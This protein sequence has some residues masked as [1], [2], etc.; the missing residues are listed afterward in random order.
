MSGGPARSGSPPSA[1][2]NDPRRAQAAAAAECVLAQDPITM[3]FLR[4]RGKQLA[5]WRELEFVEETAPALSPE[6]LRSAEA[7]DR[8]PMVNIRSDLP[9]EE[10][11][12][13]DKDYIRLYCLA[14]KYAMHTPADAFARSAREQEFVTFAHLV[15]EP[16]KFRG[17]VVHL[18]G[19][20]R[21]LRRFDAPS[22]AQAEG[23]RYAYEGWIM[24]PTRG[25]TPFCVVVPVLPEGLEPAESMD[26]YVKFDGYFL[27]RFKYLSGES[28]EKESF[29]F[30]GPSVAPTKAPPR[31]P[32]SPLIA[33]WLLYAFVGFLITMVVMILVLSWWFRRGDLKIRA[34]LDEL[35]A[36]RAMEMLEAPQADEQNDTTGPDKDP[37]Q[38]KET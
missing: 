31:A 11:P 22:Q 18:E 26:R 6:L 38:D 4:L 2:W 37:K 29:L 34:R 3:L 17:K 35:Q 23:V 27:N 24:G 28:K 20:L 5:V 14:L 16:W 25:S 8:K 32:G 9:P 13:A 33:P 36:A 10:I 19:R 21:R 7:R 15:N 30:I 1:F 12:K